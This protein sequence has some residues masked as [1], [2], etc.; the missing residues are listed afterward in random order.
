MTVCRGDVIIPVYGRYRESLGTG[1]VHCLVVISVLDMKVVLRVDGNIIITR[2]GPVVGCHQRM[3][4]PACVY[5]K[6]IIYVSGNTAVSVYVPVDVP[7]P[8]MSCHQRF[9][10]PVFGR[11]FETFVSL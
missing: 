3:D 7:G 8:V 1:T 5:I 9:V 10:E 2:T 4:C 6:V 11:L